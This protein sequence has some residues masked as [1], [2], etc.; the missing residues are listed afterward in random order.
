MRAEALARR[1]A[2]ELV[3]EMAL[4]PAVLAAAIERAAARP[5]VPLALDVAGAERSAELIAAMIAGRE[6]RSFVP[7]RAT[8]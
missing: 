8:V 4:T 6:P 1:G 3:R 2:V 5:P 7:A